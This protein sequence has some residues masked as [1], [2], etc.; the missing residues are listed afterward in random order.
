MRKHR[1]I[2]GVQDPTLSAAEGPW[3][4]S[5]ER[6]VSDVRET[7]LYGLNA[8][9]AAFAKRPEALRKVY[10]TEARIPVLKPVLAWCVK[11]RLGYR[12]VEE[13]DLDK[14]TSSRHHEGVCFEIVRSTPLELAQILAQQPA[15]PASSLLLWLDS[16]GNPRSLAPPPAV[17]LSALRRATPQRHW[18]DAN[19]RC[20][21]RCGR[22]RSRLLCRGH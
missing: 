11:H 18:Q 5:R 14:L 1:Q 22:S 17:G 15:A 7:R 19:I 4:R 2:P 3:Q 16:V 12:I 8:C 20:R 21:P 9:I 6:E 10:L 13:S